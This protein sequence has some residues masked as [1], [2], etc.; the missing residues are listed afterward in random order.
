MLEDELDHGQLQQEEHYR[1]LE[2]ERQEIEMMHQRLEFVVGWEEVAFQP[3]RAL[4]MAV[5]SIVEL[6]SRAGTRGEGA[7]TPARSAPRGRR[8]LAGPR[9]VVRFALKEAYLQLDLPETTPWSR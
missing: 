7:R 9:S 2:F 6:C 4:V 1:R 3:E 5:Q 8:E